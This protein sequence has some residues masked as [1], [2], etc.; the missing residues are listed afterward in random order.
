M[1]PP[2]RPRDRLARALRA[3]ADRL[4]G[5]G[6][7]SAPEDVPPPPGQPPEHWRRLV[8]AHAP[9]LLRDLP[10][11]RDPAHVDRPSG[12]SSRAGRPVSGDADR[13]ARGNAD[14]FP[15]RR[16]QASRLRRS[17]KALWRG[18]PRSRQRSLAPD[19]S[20]SWYE[21]APGGAVS[22]QDLP[23]LPDGETGVSGGGSSASS[24]V[25]ADCGGTG[26]R[27]GRA[28]EDIGGRGAAPAGP[29]GGPET[30]VDGGP[31]QRGT[32]PPDTGSPRPGSAS[33]WAV[34]GNEPAGTGCS[35]AGT[36]FRA[37]GDERP[38]DPAAP[39]IAPA[40]RSVPESGGPKRT[41]RIADTAHT[42][43]GA[44]ATGGTRAAGATGATGPD[45]Y[46]G[47]AATTGTVGSARMVDAAGVVV[48]R[49]GRPLRGPERTSSPARR[50]DRE[51]LAPANQGRGP[52]PG[53]VAGAD[54][55]PSRGDGH[56]FV[57]AAALPAL[58]PAPATR[59][60]RRVLAES[61]GH[62]PGQVTG[63]PYP[64]AHDAAPGGEFPAR[65]GQRPARPASAGPWPALPT[66]AEPIRTTAPAP[67]GAGRATEGGAAHA[68]PWPALP[69]EPVGW[70]PATRA[71][72]WGDTARL[73]RE[74]A[75]G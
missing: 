11:P 1:P 3:A 4:S 64:D 62:H 20:R 23:Q 69:G 75:G 17:W 68:D 24:G 49:G 21:K 18:L 38:G 65:P 19:P 27:G 53:D 8:A 73:D 35:A 39:S 12:A 59:D 60:G 58:R 63:S 71:A 66:D 7:P 57:T 56:P 45:G 16:A 61:A 2:R 32:A 30:G 51:D 15:A 36:G 42:A 72:P 37:G 5:S 14:R 52:H 25:C 26:R 6:S 48:S 29:I 40:Y 22:Y 47:S 10:P 13:S 9:G 55:P 41:P 44:G 34:V 54:L 50:S 67:T 28:R 70:T 33:T 46:A 43:G 31:A 74:Q